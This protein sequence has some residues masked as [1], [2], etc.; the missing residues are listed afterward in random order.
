MVTGLVGRVIGGM[1]SA[2]TVN[3]RLSAKAVFVL[4]VHSAGRAHRHIDRPRP[5]RDAGSCVARQQL[6][7]VVTVGGSDRANRE[8][9]ER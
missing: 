4:L 5:P 7:V 9:P 3:D 2:A 8:A 6:G 1:T